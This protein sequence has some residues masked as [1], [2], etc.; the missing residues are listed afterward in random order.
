MKAKV[1]TLISLICLLTVSAF[2]QP[3][4]SYPITDTNPLNMNG[5]QIGYGLNSEEVKAVSDKGDFSRF[6]VKFYVTNTT[7]EAKLILRNNGFNLF[8]NDVSPQIA[9]YTC[10]NATGARL[11]SKTALLEAPAARIIAAV[12]DK[13]PGSNKTVINK[14]LVDIGFWIRPGETISTNEIMIVPLNQK[15]NMTV[16]YLWN[17]GIPASATIAQNAYPAGPPPGYGQPGYQDP[18]QGYQAPQMQNYPPAAPAY[19]TIRNNFRSTYL[20]SN[21]QAISCTNANLSQAV[22]QWYIAPFNGSPTQ[23]QIKNVFYGTYLNSGKPGPVDPS[24]NNKFAGSVW[25]IEHIPNSQFVRL[26]NVGNDTYLNVETGSLQSTT[27]QPDATS[28]QWLL[29]G[30]QQQ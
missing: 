14:R 29:E 10:T 27:I 2:A 25:F 5:L 22:A 17:T 4:Q 18:S 3:P 15:P 21:S 12:E 24:N 1:F 19:Y 26:K 30:H 11:T 7:G 8:G 9:Q 23:V 13:D 20:V 6:S 16:T 28:S